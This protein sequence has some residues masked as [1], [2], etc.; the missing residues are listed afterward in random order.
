MNSIPYKT[1]DTTDKERKAEY[2]R[3]LTKRKKKYGKMYKYT[4][5]EF[6]VEFRD[7]FKRRY[8]G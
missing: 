8:G 7:K 4:L 2:M 3:K 6:N 5:E 1:D